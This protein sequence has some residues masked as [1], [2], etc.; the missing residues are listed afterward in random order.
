VSGS[1][2]VPRPSFG[3]KGFIAPAEADILAGVQADINAAFG[4]KL[5]F[6][7]SSGAATN[8][9]PQGQLA[10]SEAAI[11]GDSNDN[12][13][14]YTNQVDPAYASGRMQDGIARIYFITRNPALPTIVTATCRGRVN[15]PI[16]AGALARATDGRLYQCQSGGTIPGSGAID[17]QFACVQTGPIACPAG[18]L[19]TIYQAIPGW[20]SVNNAADGIL[21]VDVESRAEFEFRRGQSVAQNSVGQVTSILGAVFNVDGVL[22]AF[23]T[24]NDTGAPATIGGISIGANQL[25]VAAVG[26]TD[27]DVGTAIWTKKMPGGPYY[28]AANTTVT[29]LDSGSGY[30][31]PY[32]SYT[33]KFQRPAVV[34]VKFAVSIANSSLVPATALS[35]IQGAIMNAFTGGDGGLRARIGSTIYASRFY[36]GIAALG[37]WAQIVSLKIGAAGAAAA[38]TAS[39]ATNVLTVT[40]IASGV[41]AVGQL[42]AGAGVAPSTIITAFGTG[43]GGNGTYTISGSQSV[44]SEAMTGTGLADSVALTIAQAPATSPADINLF[45]V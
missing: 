25:Y 21:G 32:P 20:D 13:L 35:D 30:S 9:T 27:Q 24:A 43:T 11:I 6:S 41:L 39:I 23:V 42:I 19:S 17:L 10:A 38:F 22:D 29:V 1:T 8:A 26:G 5:N 37:P 18:S 15:V 2:S 45:L 14:F 44:S 33:V 16:P 36:P 34:S 40:A 31:L 4:G 28:S 12:F 7:T 3:D